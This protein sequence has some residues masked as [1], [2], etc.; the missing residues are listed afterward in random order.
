MTKL[1]AYLAACILFLTSCAGN[2]KNAQV[3]EPVEG[4]LE[5]I[6]GPAAV[7]YRPDSVLLDSL[8]GETDD[9]SYRTAMDDWQIY[10]AQARAFVD[11]HNI[12]VID[13]ES[14]MLRFKMSNGSVMEF[15]AADNDSP[16]GLYFFDGIKPPHQVDLLDDLEPQFQIDFA[17]RTPR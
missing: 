17:N 4:G 14:R 7:F 12:K 3:E 1:R 8:R 6:T 2:N 13:T 9:E 5:M 15:P 10:L 11:S 16:F